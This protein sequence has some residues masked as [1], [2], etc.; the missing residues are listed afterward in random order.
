MQSLLREFGNSVEYEFAERREDGVRVYGEQ[1]TA[2]WW[3]REQA[4]LHDDE[5][6]VAVNLFSDET[7]ATRHREVTAYAVYVTLGNVPFRKRCDSRNAWAR[8]VADAL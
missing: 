8:A 3:Q 7:S 6:L 1:W 4:K 5:V 2:A